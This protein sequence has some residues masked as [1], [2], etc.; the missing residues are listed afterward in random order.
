M[1]GWMEKVKCTS[2]D[3]I[4]VSLSGEHLR[5]CPQGYTCCTSGMEENLLN[6]SRIEF[7]TQVK[8][9]GRSLQVSLSGHFKSFDGELLSGNSLMSHHTKGSLY[10]T[11]PIMRLKNYE[12]NDAT[13]ASFNLKG[14]CQVLHNTE[15]FGG[16]HHVME[17]VD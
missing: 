3:V 7:E 9:S 15:P 16:S 12:K 6:L 14:F 10:I 17:L 4:L 8:E 11:L 2:D 1:N 13:Y 5:V